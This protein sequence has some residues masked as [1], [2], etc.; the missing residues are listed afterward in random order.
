MVEFIE[1]KATRFTDRNVFPISPQEW[2]FATQ[3]GVG[4]KFRIYRVYGAGGDPQQVR[5]AVVEDPGRLVQQ[6]QA[7]LCLAI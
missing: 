7:H 4:E 2:S 5:V 3:P 6:H 1:V